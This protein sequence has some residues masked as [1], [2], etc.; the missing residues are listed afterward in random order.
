MTAPR[1]IDALPPVPA[2]A[3]AGCAGGSRLGLGTWQ[4]ERKAWKEALIATLTERLGR[5]GDR[6]AASHL[7]GRL[8]AETASSAVSRSGR[9]F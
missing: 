1:D 5:T 8:T 3:A 2:L 7:W 9:S 6:S 4:I